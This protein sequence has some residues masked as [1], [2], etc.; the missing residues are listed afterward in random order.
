MGFCQKEEAFSK[1]LETR[2]YSLSPARRAEAVLGMAPPE[3][4]VHFD[5]EANWN[6]FGKECLKS[7]SSIGECIYQKVMAGVD[8]SYYEKHRVEISEK[9]KKAK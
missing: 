3:M 2:F 8:W 6:E 1:K 4:W 7:K 5:C 9:F